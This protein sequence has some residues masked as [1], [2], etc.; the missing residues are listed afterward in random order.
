MPGVRV[1]RLKVQL[2]RDQEDDSL[3]GGQSREATRAAIGGLEQA[4]HGL[5]ESLV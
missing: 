1:N 4:V 5:K 2:A 3:D